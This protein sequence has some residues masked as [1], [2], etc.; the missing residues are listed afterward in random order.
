MP[1]S[2]RTEPERL[3]ALESLHV[4]DTPPELA[5]DGLV[6]AAA[7]ACGMPISLLS[8]V[9]SDRQWFKANVGMPDTTQTPRDV[10]FCNHAIAKEGLFEV[11]DATADPRFADNLLVTAA[12]DIRFYA[13]STLRLSDGSHVGALCVIGREPGRLT[14]AQR[15]ILLHLSAAA[16]QLLEARR[17]AHELTISEARFRALSESS[18]LGVFATDADGACTY[19]NE[20]WQGIFDVTQIDALGHDWSRTLHPDDRE[21][22]LAEW[23]HS[24]SRRLDFGKEFRVRRDGGAVL[25][26]RMVSRPILSENGEISGHVGSVE[27]ITRQALQHEALE[28]AHRKLQMATE[29]GR[30]GVWESDVE[31]GSAEWTP[32]MFALFG[33]S[34]GS[35]SVCRELWLECM[36]P[37]DRESVGQVLR[38]AIIGDGHLDTEY[39]VVWSDGSVHHLRSSAHIT[40]DADGRAV[41]MLGVNWDVTP[42]RRL[43]DELAEQHELLHVT[44][45]SIGDAV[46]TT[47]ASG[48]V[49]WQNPAAEQM[50]GWTS[51]DAAGRPLRQVFRIVGEGTRLPA[52]DPVMTCMQSGKVAGPAGHTL[53]L[54]RD[55]TEYSIEDSAAPI[56]D[57][58][59]ALLGAVLVFRDVTEQRRLSLEMTY[60]ATHD[61]LTGLVNRS[62]F[63]TRLQRRLDGARE[64]GSENALMYID[65]DQFKLVNDACGHAA[66]DE[67]LSRVARLL[68]DI[69]RSR[70]TLA[71]LGGDEF[72]LILEHCNSDQA[73]RIA[74]QICDRMDVFRFV[75]D[76]RR[77]RIGTS[78]GLVPLDGRWGDTSAAMQAADIS[79][80]AAKESGRNRVHVWFDTDKAMQDRRDDMRWAT[81]L[82]Q[83][84]DESRFELHVQRIEPITSSDGGIRAEMLMRLREADGSLVMPNAFLPAAERFHLATR[85]DR[86][87]LQSTVEA[88]AGMPDLSS[89]ELLCVNLSGRSIGDRVFHRDA[90][91]LLEAA[92]SD[93]CRRL[94][95]E[96]TETAAVTNMA[97]AT[98][99]IDRARALGVRVAL[100]DFG[101]GA[102]AFGY[103]KTLAVDLLK[104]DGQFITGLIDDPLNEAAVRCFVDVAR[105]MGLKTVAE[106]VDSPE[107][108]QRVRELGIDYAQGFLLHRPEPADGGI[109]TLGGNSAKADASSS[110]LSPTGSNPRLG[111]LTG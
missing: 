105:V 84:I 91:E 9:D 23:Q 108:L 92:G 73:L 11:P 102:S 41:Q 88:L 62:E 58:S 19:V 43:S 33:L 71:R 35:G 38:E 103:L 68:G 79:C 74:Q 6:R 78:I 82:A 45:Q 99:F 5:F 56:L 85:I 15:E 37:E 3:A 72:G 109:F 77:F 47:D 54:S 36:H 20:R 4:L 64:D 80:H 107:T 55:G 63:E 26:A 66:G 48:R 104:I 70:D 2:H 60:R 27:D 61:A 51:A 67:L 13:G 106:C 110:D 40:R 12:P 76:A 44:L 32:Q 83:A 25:H 21:G 17:T 93:V 111:E 98:V 42:L 39:R 31:S 22:A 75:H 96:V 101:A 50:T 94:C 29:S 24:V 81:R 52:D 1:S 53:L 46:I 28:S 90:V 95:L 97:D 87:V 14:P 69:V 59:G 86:W 65:L 7:L 89:V 30:I 10:S 8:L 18:P 100:D 34:G 49:S 57:R 16:V